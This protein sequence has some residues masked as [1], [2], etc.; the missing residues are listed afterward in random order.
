MRRGSNLT[1]IFF[2]KAPIIH[3]VCNKGIATPREEFG[4]VRKLDALISCR[5]LLTDLF[6]ISFSLAN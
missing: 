2:E 5:T 6:L 3:H 1:K 4:L